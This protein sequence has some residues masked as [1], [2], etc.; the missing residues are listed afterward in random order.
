MKMI[1][2]YDEYCLN[3]FKNMLLEEIALTMLTGKTTKQNNNK[4]IK[5][6]WRKITN[7]KILVIRGDF[8]FLSL[9]FLHLPSF[10]Y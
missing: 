10:L 1:Q 5:T 8:Y 4:C 7:I 2:L 6:Q 9:L 3:I